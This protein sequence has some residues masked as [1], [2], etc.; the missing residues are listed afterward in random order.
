MKWPKKLDRYPIPSLGMVVIAV[1]LGYPLWP[2]SDASTVLP[3]FANII[4]AL[5]A[6]A[7]LP[8]PHQGLHGVL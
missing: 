3:I 4:Y 1:Y 5:P 8:R 2:F 7:A 6:D